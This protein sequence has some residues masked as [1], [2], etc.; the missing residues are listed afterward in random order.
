MGLAT[1][2]TIDAVADGNTGGTLLVRLPVQLIVFMSPIALFKAY[3]SW[4]LSRR[5]PRPVA[6]DDA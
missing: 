6:S 4:H 1:A 5:Q 3:V 2:W